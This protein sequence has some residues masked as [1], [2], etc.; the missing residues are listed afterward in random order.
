MNIEAEIKQLQEEL[1]YVK[2]PA[3]IEVFKKLLRNQKEIITDRISIEH[4][5]EEI[6][7]AITRVERGEFYTQEE[8]EKVMSSW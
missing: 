6:D 1:K 3:L 7:A 5:N 4:Y 2:D 8:A